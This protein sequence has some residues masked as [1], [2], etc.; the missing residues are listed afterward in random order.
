LGAEI[1][2]DRGT[3][4]LVGDVPVTLPRAALYDKE[5]SFRVS[6]SYGPG[7][8]DLEYEERGLDYPIGYVRWTEQRNMECVLELQAAGRLQLDDLV[9]IVPVER[10][11]DAYGR[12]VGESSERPLGALVLSYGEASE[13]GRGELSR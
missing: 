13:D 11:A 6:R 5:L 1:A 8:Y 2:R 9:E 4:V 3:L 12:L 10:A 7:R